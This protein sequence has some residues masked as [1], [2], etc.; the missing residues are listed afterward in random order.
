MS[1]KE[2]CINSK[3]C[4]LMKAVVKPKYGSKTILT[5]SC[6]EYVSLFLKRKKTSGTGDARFYWEQAHSFYLASSNLPDSARPLTSYYCILNMTKAL[7]RYKGIDGAS[8]KHHGLSSVRDKNEKTDINEAFTDI[9]GGGVLP[10]LS[11]YYEFNLIPGRYSMAELLYNIPCVHR[12][13]C[14]TF[15]KSEIFVPIMKPTFVKKDNSKDAW[16][17]FEVDGRYANKKALKYLP[18]KFQKDEGVSESYT[19]RTKKRF[20]WD[21]HKSKDQRIRVLEKYHEKNRKH[22][23]YIYGDSKLW[24]IK[25]QLNGNENFNQAP[26]AV[27]IFSVFHWLSELVRYNPKLFSDY[28]ASKQNWLLH[29][30]INNALDQFVD[31]ISCEIT[32]E[33]IM[34]TGYRK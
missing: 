13:Y 33:D 28:M 4:E 31:E 14:I 20:E 12:A 9:K 3:T 25:K 34:C 11:N 26:S 2:I 23:Y 15:S 18:T 30:F 32:G 22:L 7:L 6:W 5:D 24:Y 16:I 1:F 19:I 8:L 27:L 10:E 29:E 21:I 17:K